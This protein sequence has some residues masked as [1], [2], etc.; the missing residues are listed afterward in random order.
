M[1]SAG[2]LVVDDD[3]A[4]CRILPPDA[5]RRAVHCPDKPSVADVRNHR[6]K[7]FDVYVVD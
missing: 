7:P 1:S 5:F 3:I 2:I 6:T 4:V